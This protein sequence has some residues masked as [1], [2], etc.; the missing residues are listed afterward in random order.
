MTRSEE[1]LRAALR[2]WRSMPA[3]S[4]DDVDVTPACLHGV[5]VQNALEQAKLDLAEV[6]AELQWIRRIILAAVVSAA[7]ATIL[8]MGGLLQ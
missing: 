4:V 3:R 6:K 7:F 5:I 1:A 8:R 2:Q